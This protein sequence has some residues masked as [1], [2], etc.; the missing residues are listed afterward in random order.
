[1]NFLRKITGHKSDKSESDLKKDRTCSAEEP[2]VSKLV[3]EETG[4]EDKDEHAGADGESR[5]NLFKLI[6]SKIGMD[7]SQGVT[8]PVWLFEPTTTLQRMCEMLHFEE[9]LDTAADC[10]SSVERAAY[11]GAFFTTGFNGT[12]RFFKPFNP[13]LGETYE[14]VRNDKDFR[15]ISEQVC[16]HPPVSATHCET[17]KWLF[18]QESSPKTVFLGNSIDINPQ[19]KTHIMFKRTNEHLLVTQSPNTRIHNLLIGRTWIDHYGTVTIENTTTHDSVTISYTKC[20]F[21]SKGRHELFGQAID[22][23]GKVCLELEGKW[24]KSVSMNWL[25]AEG[26]EPR[27]TKKTVWSRPTRNQVGKFKVTEFVSRLNEIDDSYERLLPPTDSRLR[28]DRRFLDKGDSNAAGIWKGRLEEKQRAD[29]K[30][31][32]KHMLED[33]TPK[34]FQ[35]VREPGA[36]EGQQMWQYTGGYWEERERKQ[37]AIADAS[38]DARQQESEL[39]VA[40]G[41]RG[42]ACDFR[43]LER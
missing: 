13:I 6:Q 41:V 7:V 32:E 38:S 42:L 21:L 18:W 24:T 33:W 4:D 36:P 11:V 23:N 35:L 37:Q 29:R 14:Y 43:D 10:E 15:F 31:R 3:I 19:T 30:Q 39:L 1:M 27:G 40:R 9:L 12:E 16:H 26:S 25:Y 2:D 20:G 17:D 5:M 8:L 34:W 22:A 28:P